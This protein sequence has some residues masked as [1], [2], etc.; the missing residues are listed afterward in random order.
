MFNGFFGGKRVLVTG[1][2][3]VKGSWLALELLEAGSEVCGLDMKAPGSDSNFSASGLAGRLR[4]VRG[5]VTDLCLIQDLMASVDCVF[6]LAALALVGEAARRP[7]EAYRINTLG[8]AT[9]LEALRTSASVKY[10]V[11]VTTDKVYM[12]KQGQPWVEDDPLVA[13]GPYQ[14]SKSCADYV[15]RDYYRNYLQ[16]LGK[17]IGIG[18]AG[19][20]VIGGD[21]YSSQRTD[22]A[23]R[24]IVDCYEA[25]IE[26]RPPEIFRPLLTRPYIYGLD[27]VAGYMTLMSCLDCEGVDGEVFNFGPHERYGVENALIATKICE[28]WG[29]KIAWRT[30]TP[31]QEP[32]EKQS[33]SW[34]KAHNRLAWQPAY[35]IYEALRDTT[36]WYKEW[37]ARGKEA[38]EGAMFEFNKALVKIHQQAAQKLSIPWAAG[39]E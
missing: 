1:V 37:A 23:A 34:E 39:V 8:T 2:A 10:A 16:N 26:D 36:R 4:Y 21:F 20:V 28:L 30:G 13:N 3:G 24:I 19:N 5:D 17:R 38:G 35:T 25:L 14:V 9:V 32:F 31:R 18:R 22:G 7:L 11:F 12:A 29:G 33:V 15:I 27:V 6:H